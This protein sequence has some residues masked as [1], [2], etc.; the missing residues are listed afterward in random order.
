MLMLDEIS[1]SPQIMKGLESHFVG[2]GLSTKR[3]QLKVFTICIFETNLGNSVD[4]GKR[5]ETGRFR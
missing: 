2:F 1:K 4:E 3:D 5:Q